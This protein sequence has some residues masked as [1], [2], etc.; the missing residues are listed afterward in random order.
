VLH[1]IARTDGLDIA[2]R[3]FG[4]PDG[5]AVVLCHGLCASGRQFEADARHF[6][7]LGYRVLVPDLRG[8]G[9]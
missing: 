8:H 1:R 2:Y 7:G 4:A 6:A 9:N 3:E 5:A